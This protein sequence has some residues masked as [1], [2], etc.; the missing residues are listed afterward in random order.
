REA[1]VQRLQG[2]QVGQLRQG[3][4]GDLGVREVER[5]Q[6][7]Q[8]L[9]VFHPVIAGVCVSEIQRLQPRQ[10]L[11]PRA[12]DAR[13]LQVQRL[14]LLEREHVRQV[15]VQDRYVAEFQR[16]Q[17]RKLLQR[18]QPLRLELRGVVEGYGDDGL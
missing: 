1:E 15:A 5:L 16:L 8:R 13:A 12:R 6:V 7:G 11:Q 10:L 14:Q 9:Q 4:V 17:A 2:R 18:L 3:R